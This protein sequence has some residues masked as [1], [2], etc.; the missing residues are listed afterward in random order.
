MKI[1]FKLTLI[2]AVLLAF[3]CIF[4]SCTPNYTDTE[5]LSDKQSDEGNTDSDEDFSDSE[6]ENDSSTETDAEVGTGTESDT[7]TERDTSEDTESDTNT[8]SDFDSET[9]TDNNDVVTHEHVYDILFDQIKASCTQQGYTIYVCICGD[10]LRT[11]FRGPYSHFYANAVEVAP[12]CTEQ[13]CTLYYCECGDFEARDYIDALGHS[14]GDWYTSIQP[15]SEY[16]GEKRRECSICNEYETKPIPKIIL[17]YDFS[18]DEDG[19][20]L[21]ISSDSPIS[22]SSSFIPT[23]V[24]GNRTELAEIDKLI[25][26]EN[27]TEIFSLSEFSNVKSIVFSSNV[28]KICSYAIYN[29]MLLDNMYFE[30]NAPTLENL[31]LIINAQK[32]AIV[33]PSDGA[34]GFGNGLLFGEQ[35]LY[36]DISN[37]IPKLTLN[38]YGEK[39][40]AESVLLAGEIIKLFEDKEQMDL[41]IMPYTIDMAEYIEIK[42]FTLELTSKFETEIEKVN[43]IYSYLIENIVYDNDATYYSPYE[44]FKSNR[45]VCAG[46]IGL[47][48]DML[49]A[50][51][52]TSFYTRGMTLSGCTETVETLLK[53]TYTSDTHAWITVCFSNGDVKFYDPTWG[54][55]DGYGYMEMDAEALGNHAITFEVGGLEVLIDEVDFSMLGGIHQFLHTDGKIYNTF[56]GTISFIP[57]TTVI[58]DWYLDIVNI[59]IGNGS[60]VYID[61]THQ[62]LGTA[63]NSGLYFYEYNDASQY[64]FATADGKIYH[65][66]V[67]FNFLYTQAAT[68]GENITIKI[69]G[70]IYDN[71]FVFAKNEKGTYGVIAYLGDNQEITIPSEINGHKVVSVNAG[72]LEYNNT[73]THV[74]LSEGIEYVARLAFNKASS[75]KYVYLPSTVNSQAINQYIAFENCANL[76]EIVVSPDNPYMLSLDGNLYSKDMKLLIFFAPKSASTFILP[77][78]VEVILESAFHSSSIEYITLH[79]GLKVIGDNAFQY[80]TLKEITIPANCEIG[81]AAF[82]FSAIRTVVI[83]D[84]IESFGNSAFANCQM[85]TSIKLPSTLKAIPETAFMEATSLYEITLPSGV[86]SIAYGAFSYSG[87][88]SITLSES[89]TFIDTDA[90]FDCHRLFHINNLSALELIKC[91]EENGM[92]ALNVITMSDTADESHIAVS[93]KFVFYINDEEIYLT[94]YIGTSKDVVLPDNFNSKSYKL[95]PYAFVG[96]TAQSWLIYTYVAPVWVNELNHYGKNVESIT[97]P[98]TIKKIPDYCFEGW[99]SLKTVYYEGPLLYWNTI[100]ISSVG[101]SAILNAELKQK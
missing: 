27:I 98:T 90:F 67:V 41:L 71:G 40:A 99:I 30:G 48:H 4:A 55:M 62:A 82:M 80:S 61:A 83:E 75:L 10:E 13:G 24:T 18:E 29:C 50:I 56:D 37:E 88:T 26:G 58:N 1:S 81:H 46:Y 60:E 73:V 95:S 93:D 76:E 33:I 23:S 64:L 59:S 32:T 9:E 19:N 38:E 14:F 42:R 51:N 54:V 25:L 8:E 12:T 49:S 7:S 77:T 44:V 35:P 79:N 34:S 21:T 39:T 11:D 36:R 43:A 74:T 45:A 15:S 89:L 57:A 22:Y 20:V 17:Y 87:L 52:V 3:V 86:E 91:S 5:S 66:Y 94:N 2:L 100:E 65:P 28:E 16:E 68:F 92:I 63:F 84:G 101:N 70:L 97:I 31:A 69:N 78:S 6:E 47:M 53:E 85:L 72:F 96:S